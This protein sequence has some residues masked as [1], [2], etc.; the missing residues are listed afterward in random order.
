MV[1]FNNDVLRMQP[2]DTLMCECVQ[3]AAIPW[4]SSPVAHIED[5]ARVKGAYRLMSTVIGSTTEGQ[6]CTLLVF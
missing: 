4:E 6:L 3:L 5:L 1:V 2:S